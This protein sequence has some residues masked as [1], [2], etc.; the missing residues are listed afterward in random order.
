M[1]HSRKNQGES[2]FHQD[3]PEEILSRLPAS[4]RALYRFAL[5]KGSDGNVDPNPS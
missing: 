3:I 2:L 4:F 1:A 5:K